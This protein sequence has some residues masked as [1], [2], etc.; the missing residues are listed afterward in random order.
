MPSGRDRATASRATSSEWDNLSPEE[1]QAIRDRARANSGGSWSGF[2]Q[3]PPGYQG[4]NTTRFMIPDPGLNGRGP[5]GSGGG[6]IDWGDM[7][8]KY[9]PAVAALL[10]GGIQI[11]QGSKASKAQDQALGAMTDIA[12]LKQGIATDRIAQTAPMRDAS[13]SALLARLKQGI[14]PTPNLSGF[15]DQAN[16]FRRK[17]GT[18]QSM[19]TTPTF[20]TGR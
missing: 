11:A 19:A 6:G 4:N 10:V 5:G 18:Q 3:V 2:G 17:F 20:A 1:K 7:V 16:P 9:G 14:R 15:I 13:Q 8:A 12:K